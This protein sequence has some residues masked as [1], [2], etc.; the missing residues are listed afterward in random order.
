MKTKILLSIFLILLTNIDKYNLMCQTS[1]GICDVK[2]IE[3]PIFEYFK[4]FK[5]NNDSLVFEGFMVY[6]IE[7]IAQLERDSILK[8]KI[9]FRETLFDFEDYLINK[10]DIINSPFLYNYYDVFFDSKIKFLLSEI[11]FENFINLKEFKKNNNFNN[12]ILENRFD[13][14]NIC[15]LKI[16]KNENFHNRGFIFLYV[17][18]VTLE[19]QND[20]SIDNKFENVNL[21]NRKVFIPRTPIVNLSNLFNF[22]NYLKHLEFEE[23]KINYH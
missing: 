13:L 21:L 3:Y 20:L 17:Y 4:N 23:Y 2:N 5:I 1:N 11:K 8:F 16:Y 12:L 10:L 6:E 18:F 14:Q 19:I 15:S 9:Y 7:D 22:N